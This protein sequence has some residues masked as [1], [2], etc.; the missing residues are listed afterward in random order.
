MKPQIACVLIFLSVGI[1]LGECDELMKELGRSKTSLGGLANELVELRQI[2]RRVG[3]RIRSWE[4]KAR[5]NEVY[6]GRLIE[7]RSISEGWLARFEEINRKLLAGEISSDDKEERIARNIVRIA[8]FQAKIDRR[9][10]TI[11]FRIG[12]IEKAQAQA[13]LYR[14]RFE[15]RESVVADIEEQRDAKKL[16]VLTLEADLE[17]CKA[18]MA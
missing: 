16:L 14:S 5:Q 4:D 11:D 2:Q 17:A 13:D 3:R 7:Q 18:G 10:A 6:L 15:A 9:Q 8:E 1:A 12:K